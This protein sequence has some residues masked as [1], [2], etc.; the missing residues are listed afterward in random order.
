MTFP[1]LGNGCGGPGNQ[2]YGFRGIIN[3]GDNDGVNANMI[4]Y[5]NAYDLSTVPL[6]LP[7]LR[8]I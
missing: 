3:C 2:C 6:G 1:T 8:H 5:C 7:A 4:A